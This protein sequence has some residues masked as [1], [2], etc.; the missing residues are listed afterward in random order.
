MLDVSSPTLIATPSRSDKRLHNQWLRCWNGIRLTCVVGSAPLMSMMRK[1]WRPSVASLAT[2]N[3]NEVPKQRHRTNQLTATN[4][5]DVTMPYQLIA[6]CRHA[7]VLM[8]TKQILVA[9]LHAVDHT[10]RYGAAFH[11]PNRTHRWPGPHFEHSIITARDQ[12][13][14]P[15]R[16]TFNVSTMRWGGNVY[17]AAIISHPTPQRAIQAASHKHTLRWGHQTAHVNNWRN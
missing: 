4:T 7:A 1:L 6:P 5:I 12:V 16:H 9:G 15:D 8:A 17:A 3:E 13:P 10:V 11:A 2:N 14:V